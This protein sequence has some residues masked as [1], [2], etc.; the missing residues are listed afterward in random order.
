MK[1]YKK[2]R[3]EQRQYHDDVFYKVWRWGGNPDRIDYDRVQN[4]YYEGQD[5]EN[6]ARQELRTQRPKPEEPSEQ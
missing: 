4:Q 2:R 6:A 1:S 5:S 3:E